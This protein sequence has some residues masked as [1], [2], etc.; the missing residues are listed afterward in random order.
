MRKQDDL[1]F[2]PTGTYQFGRGQPIRLDVS[3]QISK[4][5][6]GHRTYFFPVGGFLMGW[7]L[8]ASKLGCQSQLQKAK[9]K[10]TRR[11]KS[12]AKNIAKG[13]LDSFRSVCH[14][15]FVSTSDTM[16]TFQP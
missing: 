7:R 6:Q 14:E 12:T 3:L 16:P 11:K 1:S 15:Y 8:K 2:S 10:K 4:Q 13:R 9:K 5:L